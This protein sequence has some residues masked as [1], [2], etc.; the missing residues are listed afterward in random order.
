MLKKITTAL[1]LG[2]L[3]MAC[4]GT[5]PEGLGIHDG[6]L[7]E[8]PDKPNC[9]CS[10]SSKADHKIDPLPIQ[11]S[12]QDSMQRLVQVVRAMKGSKIIEQKDDYLYVEFTSSLLRFVDD[13]EFYFPAVKNE[14]QVRSASRLGYSDFGVNRKRVKAIRQALEK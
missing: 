5:R 11:G 12:P 14:I 4:Q 13:V 9:V 2:L 1:G 6:L 7:Q 8:C 3:S 10:Q